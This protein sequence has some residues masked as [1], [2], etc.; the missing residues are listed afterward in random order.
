MILVSTPNDERARW[1]RHFTK[2]EVSITRT[3]QVCAAFVGRVPAHFAC[4]LDVIDATTLFA[5]SN[6]SL[7]FM[8]LWRFAIQSKSV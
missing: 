6:C 4:T 7:R 3:T 5:V 8:M 1:F 2:S